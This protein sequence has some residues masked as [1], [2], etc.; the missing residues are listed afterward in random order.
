MRVHADISG[1]GEPTLGPIGFD[2]SGPKQLQKFKNAHGRQMTRSEYQVIS[3]QETSPGVL[4]ESSFVVNDD[5][6]TAVEANQILTRE[7]TEIA[8]QTGCV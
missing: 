4:A 3:C 7:K 5:G 6:F 1:A 2:K 8:R